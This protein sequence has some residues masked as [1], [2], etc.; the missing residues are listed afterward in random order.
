MPQDKKN[1]VS[2]SSGELN[3]FIDEQLAKWNWLWVPTGAALIFIVGLFSVRGWF[4]WCTKPAVDTQV[5]LASVIVV[6]AVGWFAVISSLHARRQAN[7]SLRALVVAE[8]Q[9]VVSKR[10]LQVALNAEYNAASP[11]IRLVAIGLMAGELALLAR[12]FAGDQR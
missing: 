1:Q 12:M 11:V 3:R 7:L 9:A 2:D 8:N 6:A 10:A 4:P 5:S